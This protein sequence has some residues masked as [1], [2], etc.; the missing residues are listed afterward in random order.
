MHC[1]A[2]LQQ[3]SAL[4]FVNVKNRRGGIRIKQPPLFSNVR[5]WSKAVVVPAATSS[6]RNVVPAEFERQPWL[7]KISSWFFSCQSKL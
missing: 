5:F 1:F 2:S 3:G 6:I 4:L 7:Y